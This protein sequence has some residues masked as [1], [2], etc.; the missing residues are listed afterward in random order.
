MPIV[1]DPRAVL[2][3]GLPI[4]AV[5]LGRVARGGRR[6]L[7]D[8]TLDVRPGQLVAIIGASGAGKTTL[9]ET[10]AGV[11]RPSTGSVRHGGRPA[12][13][14]AIG[15]VPQDDII[16]QQL[17][18]ER[19]L[20]Y[21]ARLRLPAGTSPAEVAARVTEVLGVLG[22]TG[23][24]GTRVAS[25]SGGERK[26]ASIAVELLARPRALFL[27]EPTSGLDPAT[28]AEL[29]TFLRGRATDGVPVVLTTH[30]PADVDRCDTLVVLAPGGRLVFA[31][32]PA[33]A[34]AHFGADDVAGV[35]GRLDDAP[36]WRRSTSD[37]SPV[38]PTT[39]SEPAPPPAEPPAGPAVA[40]PA[41][42]PAAPTVGSARP[43][44]V[45]Q[46]VLL[47]RRNFDILGADK[48]TLAILIGSPLVILAM[49]LMLFRAG[50]FD[51]ARPDPPTTVMIL[52]WVAFGVFFFGL[53]Y[54]LLQICA[55]LP[56][57]RRE[58]FAG[59]RP[60]PYLAAKVALLLPPLALVDLLLLAVLRALDR[61]PTMTAG[62]YLTALLASACAL[63]LGL[64][65]SA[66]VSDVAQATLLLPMLC[67]PQVL[68]VGAI[69]PVP[70]MAPVGRAVSYTMSNRWSFEALGHQAGLP[71]L[72]R[73]GELGPPLLASYGASF[74]REPWQNWLIL[75]G[76]TLLFLAA[77]VL[78]LRV[79]CGRR[80][81]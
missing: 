12:P 42:A 37:F 13:D 17:P 18:L 70:A 5:A 56:I 40:P 2:R 21:A 29:L 68:F 79:R 19:T 53:T 4:E 77:T 45:A 48:L 67:F 47:T 75:G 24:A 10:L 9:L 23:R 11:R 25:L 28:A 65:C 74:A 64:L 32:P 69:L 39:P 76:I 78:V 36:A 44:R 72:W 14:P 66:S 38:Q 41:G 16:H 49:F 52:F 59:L 51:P 60:G 46:A 26:R 35:Y 27:D 62:L 73:R 3:P 20:R 7:D 30:N 33:H 43:G 1:D 50:A 31:G 71:E 61:L 63:A 34:P 22:L 81:G 54:G 15:Y 6:L 80:R 55:E 58:V 57:V 8:V